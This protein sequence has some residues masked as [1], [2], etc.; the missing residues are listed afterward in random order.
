[1]GSLYCT[2]CLYIVANMCTLFLVDLASAVLHVKAKIDHEM[3]VFSNYRHSSSFMGVKH[4]CLDGAVDVFLYFSA[5]NTMS[6]F[7]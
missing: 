3:Q 6:P 4:K 2:G 7:P 5:S 1:M